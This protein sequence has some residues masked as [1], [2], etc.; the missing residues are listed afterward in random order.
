MRPTVLVTIAFVLISFCV[1]EA[2]EWRGIVPL[3]S[4]RDDVRRLLGQPLPKSGEF[5]DMYDIDGARVNIMYVRRPCQLGLPGDWG[6]WNVPPY[7]V[8]NISEEIIHE[9]WFPI[10]ALGIPDIEKMKWYTD[11][12]N[13]TY[14]HDKKNGVEYTARNGMVRSITYGP[15]EKDQSLLCRKDVPVIKY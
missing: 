13:F 14:Y 15:T 10:A 3:H 6:N 4:T 1:A 2:R 12:A 5:D 7:T 8:V 11:D 9:K